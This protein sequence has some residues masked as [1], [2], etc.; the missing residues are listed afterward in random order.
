MIAFNDVERARQGDREAYLHL[1]R[2]TQ[3]L[4]SSIT[5]SL[6]SDV[7]VSEDLA[8]DVYLQAWLGLKKLRNVESFLPWLRQLARNKAQSFMRTH[9][10]SPRTIDDD[11]A[12][13]SIVDAGPDAHDQLVSEAER[14]DVARV[15]E[16]LPADAREV[17]ILF[18]R[19]GQSVAQ[20]AALLELSEVAVKKRLSRARESMR[21]QLSD[22]Q[23]DR[24][25]RSAPGESFSMG[26][27]AVLPV[28][29]P[30]MGASMSAVLIKSLLGKLGIGLGSVGIG[31]LT[32][33]L[34]HRGEMRKARDNEER[35]AL[36]R[37][38]NFSAGSM[39]LFA[40]FIIAFHST[41]RLALLLSSLPMVA[42]MVAMGW[43][44]PRIRVRRHEQELAEDP[45]A[46]RAHRRTQRWSY[47]GLAL[48]ALS[49]FGTMIWAYFH[50]S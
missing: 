45:T 50:V 25:R 23:A 8:Q 42:M 16:A 36:I 39:A 46:W 27:L 13:A 41:P 10:R 34:G 20:V 48:G 5:L 40:F 1:V 28:A 21:E 31:L 4:V 37:L 3:N 49:G 33:E 18:Y 29:A 47:F 15:L 26:V 2:A 38:R 24:V 7:S 43:W 30:T 32:L 9:Y 11:A 35:R 22:E 44:L 6:V 17:L 12:L 19:E 14:R